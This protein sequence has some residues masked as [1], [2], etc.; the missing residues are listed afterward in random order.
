MA[1]LRSIG[2]DDAERS[3]G[4]VH[5]DMHQSGIFLYSVVANLLVNDHVDRHGADAVFTSSQ[6]KASH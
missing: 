1:L 6:K 4:L 5:H 2:L 3:Y